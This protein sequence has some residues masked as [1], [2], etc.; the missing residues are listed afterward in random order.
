VAKAS[1]S[2]LIV[3]VDRLQRV[4]ALEVDGEGHVAWT[5][6]AS[7][8]TLVE[9]AAADQERYRAADRTRAEMMQRY[10]ETDQCRWRTVLGYFGQPS[11]ENCGHCDNC[12]AGRAA[13]PEPD[14]HAHPFS[15]GAPV[16]HVTFGAGEVVGYE[17]DT[18]TVLFESAGYRNLSVELV[19]SNNL[20][21][22]A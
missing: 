6:A 19:R 10:L 11:E 16:V 20:L 2:R 18:M 21:Q 7:V 13:P 8:D 14:G 22:P 15:L 17:G 12:D 4:G 1:E 9:E 5:G 3:A